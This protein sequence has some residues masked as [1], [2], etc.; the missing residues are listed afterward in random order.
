MMISTIISFFFGGKVAANYC[1][2]RGT[3]VVSAFLMVSPN[4]CTELQPIG[5]LR[6][7]L[8][9]SNDNSLLLPFEISMHGNFKS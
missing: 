7:M 2:L 3:R 6:Q 8:S 5:I 1:R 4:V 9:L